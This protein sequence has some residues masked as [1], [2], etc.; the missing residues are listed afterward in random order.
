[1]PFG[2]AKPSHVKAGAAT[3]PGS[4]YNAAVPAISPAS[5]GCS[6]TQVVAVDAVCLMSTSA[7]ASWIQVKDSLAK[8]VDWFV[9]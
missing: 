9:I 8:W 5:K 1:M 2:P 7:A 6:R 4:K 3:M